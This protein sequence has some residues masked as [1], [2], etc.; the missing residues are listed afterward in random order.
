ML[1]INFGEVLYTT[2]LTRDTHSAR[3]RVTQTPRAARSRART[4]GR[5]SSKLWPYTRNWAKSRGWALFREWALFR[6]TTVLSVVKTLKS[7][8]HPLRTRSVIAQLTI[9]VQ[10]SSLGFKS[11]SATSG[12]QQQISINNAFIM[13]NI[14]WVA[15]FLVSANDSNIPLLQQCDA[16]HKRLIEIKIHQLN[17]SII[18]KLCLIQATCICKRTIAQSSE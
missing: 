11:K 13:Y 10:Q 5:S 4:G 15:P 7:P 12:E 16:L 9:W 6:K 2:F 1:C 14:E 18:L 17:T 8:T 3:S